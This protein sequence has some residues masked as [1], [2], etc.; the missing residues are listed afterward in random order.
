[1]EP[2]WA[3]KY[4]P[5]SGN[6]AGSVYGGYPRVW[7]AMNKHANYVSRASCNTGR[8]P[9]GVA[10]DNC[11]PSIPDKYRLAFYYLRNVGSRQQNMINPGTCVKSIEPIFYPGTE[12]FWKR[13]DTFDGWLQYPYGHP[14]SPYYGSLVMHFEYLYFSPATGSERTC[15]NFGVN[16]LGT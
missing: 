11:D 5:S 1:M 2:Y 13:T 12:C 14:A 16:R 4:F 3:A 9:G 10:K 8:G 6:L 7:V 15:T